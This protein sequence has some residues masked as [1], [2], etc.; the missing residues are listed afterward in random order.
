M[1]YKLRKAPNRD[2]YWVVNKETGEKYSKEPIPKERAK[3]QMKALYANTDEMKGGALI[4]KAARDARIK[5][6]KAIDTIEKVRELDKWHPNDN[7]IWWHYH[8]EEAKKALSEEKLKEMKERYRIYMNSVYEF[9]DPARGQIFTGTPTPPPQPY[10]TM[11]M[12]SGRPRTLLPHRPRPTPVTTEDYVINQIRT[13][14]TMYEYGNSA[15]GMDLKG[16]SR[17]GGEIYEPW[18]ADTDTARYLAEAELEK[19]TSKHPVIIQQRGVVIN[20]TTGAIKREIG[21][22]TNFRTLKAFKEYIK[23]TPESR[24]NVPQLLGKGS[25]DNINIPKADF[26]KEHEKL[27]RILNSGT[28][29]EQKAEARDQKEELDKVLKGGAIQKNLLQQMAQSAYPGKTKLNIGDYKLVFSTPTLKFYMNNKKEIVVSIRGTK[30]PETA[31]I[32]ADGLALIGNLKSSGRYKKDLETLENFQKKF[33]KSEYH[34]IGVAHS[35]G[36]AILDLFIRAG[37]LRNGLSY[38]GLVEPHELKGNQR[39]YRIYH[40]EDPIYKIIGHQIPNVEVVSTLEPFWKYLLEYSLPFGLGTLFKAYDSHRIAIFRGRGETKTHRE[41]VLDTYNLEDK[42]YSIT[43]LSKITNVPKSTLQEVYNRGIGAYKTNPT[44]VRMKGSF[45]KNIDA[46]MSKKLSKQQW[47]MAR[48]YSFLDGN[49]EH[50]ED[51]R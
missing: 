41:N 33:P 19:Q 28:R 36:A 8:P 5:Q 26:I 40:K 14:Y 51:L 21:Y 17:L 1:P 13:V 50:D 18:I 29:E 44:S 46:P 2:L 43:A 10:Q 45:K 47:A 38:N 25:M 31:D 20:G 12:V 34:Y 27:L 39:H 37:L 49:E 42:P 22:H 6:V 3:A 4:S 24:D 16:D 23:K 48:V 32:E 30:I 9:V 7:A 15:F 35:L 11:T